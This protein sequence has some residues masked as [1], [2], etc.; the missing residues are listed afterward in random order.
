MVSVAP[1]AAGKVGPMKT[2]QKERLYSKVLS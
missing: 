2:A 1:Y